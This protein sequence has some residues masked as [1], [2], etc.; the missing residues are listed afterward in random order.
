MPHAEQLD[1]GQQHLASQGLCCAVTAKCR[2]LTGQ[3]Q[4]DQVALKGFGISMV[5][6]DAEDTIML[7]ENTLRVFPGRRDSGS[8]IR[9]DA[10]RDSN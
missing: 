4:N 6:L 8:C 9:L 3:D 2:Q 5:A 1:L 10:C 7:L